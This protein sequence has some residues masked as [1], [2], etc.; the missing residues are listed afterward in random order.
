MQNLRIESD[1]FRAVLLNLIREEAESLKD[2]L[3]P[4]KTE[5]DEWKARPD[6][7]QEMEH[8]VISLCDRFVHRASLFGQYRNDP[9]ASDKEKKRARAP[10]MECK[11]SDF[12]LAWQTLEQDSK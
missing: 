1:A 12:N 9:N 11:E 6:F 7:I 5:K 2:I 3:A 10:P 8:L 4:V